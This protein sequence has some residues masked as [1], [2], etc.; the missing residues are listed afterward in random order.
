[1]SRHGKSTSYLQSYQ[2]KFLN[3]YMTKKDIKTNLLNHSEAKVRLLGEYLKR[4]LSVISN[5]GFTEKINVFDLFCGQGIYENGGE[6]SPIVS[7]KHIKQTFYSVIDRRSNKLP[8]INC[9]FNDID[10][11]KIELL[12]IAIKTKSLHYGNFGELVLTSNAYKNEVERLKL[13]FKTFK[14]EKAF[15][16]I[17]PYGYKEVK[18][19]DIKGLMNCNKKAEVLLWLPIQFMYRF[20]D[21]GTP[22]VLQNFINELK[23]NLQI[24]NVS[25]VWEFIKVLKNG[26]QKYLGDDFFVD[27]FSLKKEENTVFCLYFFSPHIKGF[28]KMLEAKWEIDTEQGRGWEYSGNSP[29]LFFEQ[30]TNDLEESLKVFLKSKKCYNVDVYE[31]TLR[32]GYLPKHTV[33]IFENWQKNNLLKVFLSNNEMA[34]KKAFYLKYFKSTAIDYKKVYFI[35]N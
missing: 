9:H 7:L 26:F 17:D 22:G 15:V 32:Q 14:N 5:D 6:G 24:E 31:F 1:M 25:G 35:T 19:E 23:L 2:T 4:Y 28:E 34:R 21:N 18:A 33:E 16:F 29:S 20:A 27:N 30:K 12:K 3:I 13:L 10:P 11:D 8:K